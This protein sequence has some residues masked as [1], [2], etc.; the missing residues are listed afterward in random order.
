MSAHR[1][2]QTFPEGQ[3]ELPYETQARRTRG[4]YLR[5]DLLPS[6]ATKPGARADARA[7]PA[8]DARPTRSAR[9]D[10][11][12]R[13]GRGRRQRRLPTERDAKASGARLHSRGRVA[14]APHDAR[15]EGRA[16]DAA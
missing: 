9:T 2:N 4:P 11:R 12:A 16:D 5:P 13:V 15:R 3:E 7:R 1:S 14:S 6:L 8:R 10:A